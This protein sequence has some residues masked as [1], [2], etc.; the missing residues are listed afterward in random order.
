MWS[1]ASSN[2][3]DQ[4]ELEGLWF[5]RFP[6]CARVY[7]LPALLLGMIGCTSFDSPA[8]R[9]NPLPETLSA[10][11][12]NTPEQAAQVIPAQA[13]ELKAGP[14]STIASPNASGRRLAYSPTETL[15]IDLPTVIRLVGDNSPANQ[16]AEAKVREAQARLR[17]ANLQ[18]LPNLSVGVTYNRF[19]GQTQNQRG[20]VFGVSRANLFGSGGAGLTLDTAEAVYR[21]IIERRLLNMEQLRERATELSTENDAINAYLDLLQV[22]AQ[23]EIN[24]DTLS[25]AELM[26][27]AAREAR[28]EKVDRTPGDVFARSSK[29]NS[30]AALPPLARDWVGNCSSLPMSNSYPPSLLLP[31]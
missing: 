21:P 26:Y 17:G 18:W 15:P 31:R 13:I 30:W 28:A 6:C 11:K 24:A 8:K 5:M 16:V 20:E 29:S 4:L 10:K 2:L 19:D 23:L 1:E 25:K 14:K 3:A 9:A 7:A 27:H 12:L 22:Y